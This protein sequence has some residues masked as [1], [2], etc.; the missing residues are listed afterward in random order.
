MPRLKIEKKFS[1]VLGTQA[2]SAA[3][4]RSLRSMKPMSEARLRTEK[5][6]F[7]PRP[8]W[9]LSSS[10]RGVSAVFISTFRTSRQS[11]KPIIVANVNKATYLMT[12]SN[13]VCPSI[14]DEFAGHGWVNHS[15][16]EYVR[17]YFWHTPSEDRPLPRGCGARGTTRSSSRI[18]RCAEPGADPF[19]AAAHQIDR[20]KPDSQWHMARFHH[21]ANLDRE[22]L[23]ASVAFAQTGAGGLALQPPDLI[24]G[25]AAMR[26]DRAIRPKPRSMKR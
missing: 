24:R 3:R 12:D 5:T 23:A 2:R 18:E 13:M 9:C 22:R 11:L 7:R 21:S 17:A 1:T 6:T 8:L 16:E 4:T 20:L 10:A 15:A 14:G 25:C 26:A 19:L